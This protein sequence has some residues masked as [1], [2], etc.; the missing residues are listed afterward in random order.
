MSVDSSSACFWSACS[1]GRTA[2]AMSTAGDP[3]RVFKATVRNPV[4]PDRADTY[5]PGYLVISGEVIEELADED[6]G[7]RLGSAEYVDLGMQTIVP[8]FVD[9]HVHLPQFL[10]MGI[11]VGELLSW[12]TNYTYPEEARFA[13]SRHAANVAGRFFDA[14]VANG[15]TTAV[16]YSSVHEEAT[17]I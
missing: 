2:R 1:R 5:S 12:L 6:P 16:V 10:I 8:G 14:M 11:G 7:S 17:D 3:K 15:T 13:D 4:T 9:T